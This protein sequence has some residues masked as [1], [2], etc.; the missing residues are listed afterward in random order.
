MRYW[1]FAEN[2]AV[3]IGIF[4]TLVQIDVSRRQRVAQGLE[5]YS[6]E[7]DAAMRECFRWWLRPCDQ[8]MA[9]LRHFE[10]VFGV[11][12]S[13]AEFRRCREEAHDIV[14]EWRPA[15]AN[16][17]SQQPG[18]TIVAHAHQVLTTAELSEGLARV[19]R[20]I[21]KESVALGFNPDDYPLF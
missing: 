19:S 21:Q 1:D 10:N 11:V 5:E 16:L 12:E 13:A 14:A 4:H 8:A 15:R 18:E 7:E 2:L 9:R 6:A 3:G 17:V 20:P